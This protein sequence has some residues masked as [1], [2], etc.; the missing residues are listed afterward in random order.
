MRVDSQLRRAFEA[1]RNFQAMYLCLKA[2][3]SMKACLPG[4]CDTVV[5]ISRGICVLVEQGE[6]KS[7]LSSSCVRPPSLE[8]WLHVNTSRSQYRLPELLER[9]TFSLLDM[10]TSISVHSL[11]LHL[12]YCADLSSFNLLKPALSF[13]SK[14]FSKVT[15]CPVRE[16]SHLPSQVLQQRKSLLYN[17]SAS[18]AG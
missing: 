8:L 14:K 5:D 9:T 12:V 3:C 17:L 11:E 13:P 18:G 4:L 1:I 10:E 16:R 6:L 7:G 2:K 15:S